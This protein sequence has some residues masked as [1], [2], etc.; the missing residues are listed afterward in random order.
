MDTAPTG[1]GIAGA[2]MDGRGV[3]DGEGDEEDLRDEE[4]VVLGDLEV[5]TEGE[6]DGTVRL[7]DDEALKEA[8]KLGLAVGVGTLA[9]TNDHVAATADVGLS[10][11]I[12]SME[13][14]GNVH[15]PEPDL[16]VPTDSI[17]P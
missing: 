7:G 3:G 8:L 11:T 16:T 1:G 2:A 14:A 17:P 13:G 12:A 15:E 4:R 5:E 10:A 6:G 9:F